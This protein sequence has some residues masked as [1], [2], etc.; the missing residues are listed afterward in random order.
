[1]SKILGMVLGLGLVVVLAGSAFAGDEAKEV[2]KDVK[3][4]T[5][6]PVS[7]KAIDKACFVDQDGKRVYFCCKNCI[8][9]FK[10][11]PAK[12]VKKL[13]DAGVTLEDAPK[14]EVKK[15]ETKPTAK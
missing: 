8:D 4:Q 13:T 3:A 14:V 5:T 2:K 12:F 6:C 1:M 10:K 7:G 11:E 15:E 9:E